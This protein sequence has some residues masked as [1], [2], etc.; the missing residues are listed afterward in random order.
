MM[1]LV[2]RRP[3]NSTIDTI[4]ARLQPVADIAPL[5][6][7]SVGLA[8]YEDVIGA[9]TSDQPQQGR[10]EPHS[11]SGLVEHITPEFAREAAALLDA[12]ASYFFQIRAVGGAVSDVDPGATAYAWR[13]ANFSVAALGTRASG[14]DR[15]WERIVPHLQGLYLSFETDQGDDVL[16]R[17]FPPS[18]LGRL[19][20]LKR[21][22]DPTGLFR[23]N[24][25]ISPD[26]GAD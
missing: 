23:D 11:H 16:G 14:L 26:G 5:S 15:Y 22:Y 24:F 6:D 12:G 3:T 2:Q 19:R 21:R 7:Q 1:P 9:F 25:F 4:V 18:H 13:S 17:A 10:G 20:E 8:T